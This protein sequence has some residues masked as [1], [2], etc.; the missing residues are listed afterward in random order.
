[1]NNQKPI[2]ICNNNNSIEGKGRSF[3]PPMESGF[4]LLKGR[5]FS[6]HEFTHA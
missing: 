3:F 5:I 2:G 6:P 1:L 4:Y